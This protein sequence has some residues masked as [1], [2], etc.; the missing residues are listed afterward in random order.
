MYLRSFCDRLYLVGDPLD[1]SP[2][3]I[4]MM[5]YVVRQIVFP[6]RQLAWSKRKS[7]PFGSES[8]RVE[9]RLGATRQIGKW[10]GF[11]ISTFRMV[12]QVLP[13]KIESLKR[14]IT[15]ILYSCNVCIKDIARIAGYIV[16]MTI[17]IGSIA[18][19][20]TRQMYHT[21]AQRY[22]WSD[23]YLMYLVGDP[24]DMSPSYILMMVYVVR[25][26]AFPLRQLAWS[27]RKI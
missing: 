27:K 15:S 17:A 2:S 5:V 10:L 19:L 12:Y 14:K 6:L 8:K 4:L 18:R 7:S 20:L 22:C 21:I 25:Q 11:I 23:Y 24:L 13:K 16:S 1:M 26:I 3:Y 9:E